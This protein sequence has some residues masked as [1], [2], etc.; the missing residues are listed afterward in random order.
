MQANNNHL[1]FS[2]TANEYISHNID[3]LSRIYPSGLR[4][5]SSNYNPVPLWNVGCQIGKSDINCLFT[6]LATKE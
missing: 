4:A 1:L 5:D 3:K 6:I 2:V